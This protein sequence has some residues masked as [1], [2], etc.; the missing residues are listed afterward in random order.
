MISA[1]PRRRRG[2]EYLEQPGVADDVRVRAQRDIMR[3]NALFGGTRA[4]FLAM[5]PWLSRSSRGRGRDSASRDAALHNATLGDATLLDVG[6]GLADLPQQL[7]HLARGHGIAVHTV[8]LDASLV[9]LATAREA[10]RINHAVDGDALML[11]FA[12]HSVDVVICS[13]LLHHFEY[14]RGLRLI[15]ELHRVARQH[16]I[17]SDLRRSWVAV[18]GY[19]LSCIVLR[20]HP[21]TRHD[22]VISIL[23]GFTARELRGMVLSATG[24]TVQ[25]DIRHRLGFRLIA[26]W[27]PLQRL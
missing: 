8:G 2:V 17:V 22:G 5:R 23:R 19:W 27:S 3:A 11:P 9:L 26:T 6:T 12:D 18:A 1:T 4:V 10:G 7:Q 14:E 15:A 25:P 20:F 21:V 24:G 16:V 13:Q